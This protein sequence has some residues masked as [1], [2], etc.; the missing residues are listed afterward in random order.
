MSSGT[1]PGELDEGLWAAV[2][3]PSRRRLLDL[4]LEQSPRTPTELAGQ[5]PFSRQAVAKHL[6]VLERVGLVEG[7]R[8]GR[9]VRYTVRT[10]RLD[11]AVRELESVAA[12]WDTRLRTIKRLAETA[13]R[14]AR[15]PIELHDHGGLHGHEQEGRRSGESGGSGQPLRP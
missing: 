7:R 3:E 10:R 15:R 11:D 13:H 9:E 14:E 1:V 12:H 4:L 6:A 2:A 5:V 8:S